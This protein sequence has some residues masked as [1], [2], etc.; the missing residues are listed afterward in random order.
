MLQGK[1]LQAKESESF[2]HPPIVSS[3]DWVELQEN[4]WKDAEELSSLVEQMPENLLW[5]HFVKEEYGTYYR[6]LHGPIEHCHYHLGQIALIKSM[7]SSNK[8]VE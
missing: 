4:M 5:E 7:L 2:D 8:N 6:C 1:L 3:E